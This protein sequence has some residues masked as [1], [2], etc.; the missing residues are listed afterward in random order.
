MS[1]LFLVF[2]FFCFSVVL[3]HVLLLQIAHMYRSSMYHTHHRKSF[4][5]STR[6]RRKK[7]E[8]SLF[9]LSKFNCPRWT[10]MSCPQFFNTIIQSKRYSHGSICQ[11]AGGIACSKADDK[12]G[13]FFDKTSYLGEDTKKM[14][15][16]EVESP[17]Y[18]LCACMRTFFCAAFGF[19]NC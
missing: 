17:E 12:I 18:V 19:G 9:F 2:L 14:A 8:L 13:A 11:T 4:L 1:C 10:R 5:I 16:L 7:T 15:S 3:H 6:R